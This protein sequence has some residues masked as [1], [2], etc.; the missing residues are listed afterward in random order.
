MYRTGTAN[1]SNGVVFSKGTIE[2]NAN[3]T[4]A[5]YWNETQGWSWFVVDGSNNLAIVRS[6]TVTS[7]NEWI[8]V[9]GV[10]SS[11]GLYLYLNGVL[12]NSTTGASVKNS[13]HAS[14][15]GGADTGG[16]IFAAHKGLIDDVRTYDRALTEP[17]IRR[18]ASR[19]GIGLQPTRPRRIPE[20]IAAGVANPVLFYNHYA[21][22]GFF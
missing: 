1:A 5:L 2:G 17:E 15:I 18:L 20:E 6:N 7:Q 14:L 19:R 22:Q 12:A 3:S 16:G 4:C 10:A 13:T 9:C 11:A 8:H 21:N